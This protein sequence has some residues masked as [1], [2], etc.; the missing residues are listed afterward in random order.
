MCVFYKSDFGKIV[1]KRAAVKIILE[2]I[3]IISN[4]YELL[5]KENSPFYPAKLRYA[6]QM[7]LKLTKCDIG[8]TDLLLRL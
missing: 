5:F 8:F 1:K 4:L 2:T 6:G 3:L 7:G